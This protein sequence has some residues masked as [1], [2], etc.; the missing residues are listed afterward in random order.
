MPTYYLSG[1]LDT[2][3]LTTASDASTTSGASASGKDSPIGTL[4]GYGELCA[5]NAPATWPA[6][7]SE[8]AT[9]ASGKGNIF[10]STSLNNVAIIAGN[11]TPTV[12]L[13]LTGTSPSPITTDIIFR[14]WKWNSSTLLYTKFGVSTLTAQTVSTAA[15]TFSL[16]AVSLQEIALANN[17]YL[18]FD[19]LANVTSNPN[20]AG[21]AAK[22]RMNYSTSA[23]T[24]SNTAQII[25][26]STA[27]FRALPDKVALL[28]TSTRTLPD[29]VAMARQRILPDVVAL[30]VTSTRTLPN[31]VA[32][33]VTSTRVLPDKA[34]LLVTSN[35]TIPDKAALLVTSTRILPDKTALLVTSIRSLT[36][37]VALRV[38]TTRILPNVVAIKTTS[39]RTLPDKAAL[40]VTSTR[41]LPDK[42]ALLVTGNRVLSGHVALLVTSTRTLVNHVALAKNRVLPE[43]VAIA[44]FRVL[45]SVV[46]IQAPK[47]RILSNS[48][49]IYRANCTAIVHAGQSVCVVRSGQCIVRIN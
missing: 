22:I 16:P 12:R 18:Y 36:N 48:V 20:G 32:I 23:T 39:T 37:A 44:R 35:R 29:N 26:P 33:L 10:N 46:A 38:T 21:V 11:W 31:K 47:S 15:T 7:G 43:N 34:A 42:V 13:T 17:E 45:P 9:P 5:N 4:T 24:G 2:T 8:S 14:V 6:Y 25:S 27:S 49:L 40:L 30:L 28:V 1:V 41:A 19:V 3:L